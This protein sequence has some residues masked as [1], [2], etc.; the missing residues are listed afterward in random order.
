MGISTGQPMMLLTGSVSIVRSFLVL[1]RT[2]SELHGSA[3]A[4]FALGPD[5]SLVLFD[6]VLHD[7]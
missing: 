2:K 5:P 1:D 7:R 3:F 6:N 4:I